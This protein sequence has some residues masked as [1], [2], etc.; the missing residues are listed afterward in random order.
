M[1]SWRGH[2]TFSTGLG[3]VYGAVSWWQF[4]IDWPVAAVGGMLCSIGG[5]L[6]DLDSHSG[7]PVRELSHLAAALVPLVLLRRIAGHGLSPEQALLVVAGAYLFIR[8]VLTNIFRKLTVH[9]GM[10]HSIPAMLIA[11]LLTFLG[12]NHPVL[13]S[14]LY[15]AVAV[16]LGFLSH[17][18]LD[19]MC[20]VDLNGMIP[21][22]NQYAG[23]AVKF[24]SPSL[25]STLFTYVLLLGL[26]WEANRELQGMEKPNLENLQAHHAERADAGPP[27]KA[28]GQL[29]FTER[30]MFR[31]KL[32]ERFKS[33]LTPE[34][35]ERR[36]I[37]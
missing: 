36:P 30:P 25:P 3:V 19:E 22:L 6:P 27:Q 1:A 37:N 9:R 24:W 12:F 7:V 8:Y 28:P 23:T 29:G 2:L 4:G 16:M 31:S 26:G 18:V 17:L 33:K 35:G 32:F 10:F 11:G 13:E 34:S 15:F 5:L 20:S 21:K 14:R